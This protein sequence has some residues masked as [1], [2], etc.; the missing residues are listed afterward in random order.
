[1]TPMAM[2][3]VDRMEKYTEDDLPAVTFTEEEEK[4]LLRRFDWILLP[5]MVRPARRRN[6]ATDAR[7]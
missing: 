3:S 4:A 6:S 7:D 2:E 1:M 5:V